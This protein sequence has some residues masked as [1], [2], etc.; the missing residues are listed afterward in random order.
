MIACGSRVASTGVGHDCKHTAPAFLLQVVHYLSPCLQVSQ[1]DSLAG[2]F[3]TKGRTQFSTKTVDVLEAVFINKDISRFNKVTK[4]QV[5]ELA[6]MTGE[7]EARV[8]QWYKNRVERAVKPY[9]AVAK[10]KEYVGLSLMESRQEEAE[11]TGVAPLPLAR[12]SI[13]KSKTPAEKRAA[14][15]IRSEDKSKRTA[16]RMED[17]KELL[18][19]GSK[20]AAVLNPLLLTQAV[21]LAS[22]PKATPAAAKQGRAK[23]PRKR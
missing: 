13:R 19:K 3:H 15:V 11:R 17:N 14:Q 18:E 21:R 7:K 22:P 6:G 8:F 2:P 4:E 5:A 20:E 16:K 23:R 12:A 10:R 1:S 9:K